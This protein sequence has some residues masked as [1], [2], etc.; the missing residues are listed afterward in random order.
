MGEA[1]H[2]LSKCRQE[3]KLLIRD[4]VKALDRDRVCS[5]SCLWDSLNRRALA[6]AVSRHSRIAT[7]MALLTDAWHSSESEALYRRRNC[8]ISESQGAHKLLW[9]SWFPRKFAQEISSLRIASSR[10]AR[11]TTGSARPGGL[12]A[13]C[14]ILQQPTC[15]GH[16]FW[17][18]GHPIQRTR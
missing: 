6:S 7:T 8:R 4:V 11:V 2:E 12:E 17:S 5:V 1:E 18:L 16:R 3:V 9:M 13:M 15:V 10:R 14:Y